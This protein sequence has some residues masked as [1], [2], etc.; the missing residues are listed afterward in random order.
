M[1]FHEGYDIFVGVWIILYMADQIYFQ[2]RRDKKFYEK[3]RKEMVDGIIADLKESETTLVIDSRVDAK[4]VF[5]K[6]TGIDQ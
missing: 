4:S 3:Y 6:H 1:T 2:R 5:V